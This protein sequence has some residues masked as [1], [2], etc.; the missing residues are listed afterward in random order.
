MLTKKRIW[1][2][3]TVFAVAFSIFA[4]FTFLRDNTQQ[5]VVVNKETVA[6]LKK[7]MSQDR[8]TTAKSDVRLKK[9]EPIQPTTTQSNT[10]TTE[11]QSEAINVTKTDNPTQLQNGFG[12]VV[13]EMLEDAKK[14]LSTSDQTPQDRQAQRETLA[15]RLKEN[16]D[17]SRS[18]TQLALDDA[19]N[20]L[21][22]LHSYLKLTPP[23]RREAIM[24]HELRQYPDE[25]QEIRAF[26]NRINN[27]PDK[28]LE[29]IKAED[30]ENKGYRQTRQAMHDVL[31]DEFNQILNDLKEY[32]GMT[33]N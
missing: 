5:A 7:K 20:E 23:A 21:Q 19:A 8:S 15:R 14:E 12:A 2:C 28:T 29:Q 9:S 33:S 26:F 16:A 3:V 24:Q 22:L 6:A 18:L 11:Q 32:A 1:F 27:A 30:Q 4:V 31:S 25:A 13:S 17:L 10:F